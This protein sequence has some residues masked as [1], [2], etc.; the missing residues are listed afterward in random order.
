MNLFRKVSFARSW[1]CACALALSACG[2]AANDANPNRVTV[3]SGAVD[4]ATYAGDVEFRIT[5]TF[6]A[7]DKELPLTVFLGLVPVSD[8]RLGANAFVDLRGVQSALP[9]LLTGTL[10]PSCS[11]GLDVDFNDAEAAGDTIRAQAVVTARL[12]RC[13]GGGAETE[14]RGLR[15]LAQTIDVDATARGRLEGDCIAFHLVDLDL[16]PRGLLGGVATLFGITE[17]ARAAIVEKTRATLA[18]NPVCPDLPEAIDILDP[19]FSEITLREIGD[20]GMGASASGSVDLRPEALVDLLALVAAGGVD[21]GTATA[22]QARF[23]VD[24]TFEAKGR[25]I[26][27]GLDVRLA[28][29]GPARIGLETTLDLRDLQN[30]LPDLLAGEVLVD[31][32][33]GQIVME[34]LEAEAQDTRVIAKSHLGVESY[35]CE[36][37][38]PGTWERGAVET[39]EKV[40]VRAEMSAELIGECVTFTLLELTR[41]PPGAF[42]RLDT[43]NGRIEAARALMLEA[44]RLLLEAHPLCPDLPP[45]LMVL[46]PQFDHGTPQE[47]A[48]GGIGVAVDG[49]IDVS[50][51]TL[52]DLLSLLQDRGTVPPSP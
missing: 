27:Y 8:T 6:S 14:Q 35:D 37:T 49:S 7:R 43:G 9:D 18:E 52:V 42:L 1:V 5:E 41:D 13:K 33:G 34:R 22:G 38:G 3:R 4:P 11:L 20:G 45:E 48:D 15:L 19:Q 16:D 50:P 17:K 10:D 12:Y 40:D 2:S 39:A 36:R 51:Q 44:V 31:T 26:P 25:T 32:C 47:I 28:T 30:R 21:Q 24:E 23:R 29:A 46:D